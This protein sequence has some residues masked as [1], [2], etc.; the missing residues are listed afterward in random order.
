[1]RR[2]GAAS[3]CALSISQRP[4]GRLERESI[5]NVPNAVV[6]GA[7]QLDGGTLEGPVQELSATS[8]TVG[9]MIIPSMIAPAVPAL[10]ALVALS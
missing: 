2:P 9:L 5:R 8:P 1:V 3:D 7:E 10:S 6:F 4:S